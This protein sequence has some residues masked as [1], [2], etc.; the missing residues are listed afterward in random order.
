M[1]AILRTRKPE[2]QEFMNESDKSKFSNTLFTKRF[3]V[4]KDNFI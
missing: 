2:N 1:G 3:T 4:K